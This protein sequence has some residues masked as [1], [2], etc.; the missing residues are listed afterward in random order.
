MQP[1]DYRQSHLEKGADYDI[2]L[3]AGTFDSY[4][5]AREAILL[6]RIVARLFPA[7]PP[8]YLDFACGTG[9][10][11][12]LAAP[13][14][15]QSR[16][17]D[18][19]EAMLEEARKKCPKTRF[20]VRDIT[21]EPLE[22][23]DFELITAFRF[24]GNAQPDLRQAVFR[25]VSQHLVHGGY[26]VFNNHRNHGSF[27]ARLQRAT[28]RYED[29]ADLDFA[30]LR[31][32]LRD[33]GFVIEFAMG[34]GWWLAAHRLDTPAAFRS[35]LVRLIEPVSTLSW[36]APY[37]PAYIVVARKIGAPQPEKT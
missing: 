24:F 36:M 23:R 7:T 14:S 21:A 34:I 29:V 20:D 27:R 26:L 37:C 31:G 28:G 13:L 4:M 32:L 10:I 3:A 2:A 17:V 1:A 35:S 12:S 22:D 15:R 6:P 19:S 5:T 25:A 33:A 16:G 9:R 11:T 18:V 8:K 30:M